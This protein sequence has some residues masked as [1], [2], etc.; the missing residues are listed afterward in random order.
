MIVII[1]GPAHMVQMN[2]DRNGK[3][4]SA[5]YSMQSRHKMGDKF[6][7]P[8][9]SAYHVERIRPLREQT[10]PSY[11]MGSRSHHRKADYVPS[12]NKYSLPSL[13]GLFIMFNIVI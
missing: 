7:T 12:P 4:G 8:S 10:G 2:I 6:N 5:K 11:S 13:L 9:P 1:V 3:E